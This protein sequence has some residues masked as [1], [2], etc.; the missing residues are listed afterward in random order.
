MIDVNLLT[1]NET[2]QF[3][4]KWKD[5]KF[6]YF[7]SDHDKINPTVKPGHLMKIPSTAIKN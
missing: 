2:S 7:N 6:W 4:L 3:S 1:Q 5:D